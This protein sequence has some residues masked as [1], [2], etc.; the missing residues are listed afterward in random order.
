MRE[1]RRLAVLRPPPRPPPAQVVVGMHGSGGCPRAEAVK[2]PRCQQRWHHSEWP[3]TSSS[4]DKWAEGTRP[5][6]PAMANAKAASIMGAFFFWG[7][8]FFSIHSFHH[9]IRYW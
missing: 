3:N 4:P 6:T 5:Q 9:S 8:T 2:R 1:R 7:M